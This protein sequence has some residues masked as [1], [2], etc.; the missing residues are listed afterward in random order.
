M[1]EYR[2][3]GAATALARANAEIAARGLVVTVVESYYGVVV[4]QRQ[5]SNAQAGSDEAQH[6]LSISEKLERGGEVAHSDVIKARLQAND[7]QRDLQEAKLALD[8]TRLELAVLLFP[9]FTQDYAVVDDLRFSSPL[10]PFAEAEQ[11]AAQNNP[12]LKAAVAALRV[13]NAE[14]DVARG[15]HLPSL[16]LDYFYG[17]DATHFAVRTDGIRNLGYSAVATLNV[18]VFNW[19]ATQSKVRQ[20]SLQQKQARLELTQAQR[21]ALANLRAFYAEADVAKNELDVLR[22]SA[23]LAAESLRLTNL[24]YQGGE[25]TALEVVDAQNTLVQARNAYDAGEARYRV[26]LANL[27]TLTGSF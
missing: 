16:T 13:A 3:A 26:A 23:E 6:F 27:Q 5:M 11:M 21:Q 22:N 7:R 17:I 10:P 8:K 18:P 4:A 25:A 14:L 20:A 12:D 24:R 1:A 19:G 9:Q 15:G 2:R